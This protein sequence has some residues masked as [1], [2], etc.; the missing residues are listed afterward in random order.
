MVGDYDVS[1]PLNES[2]QLREV[3]YVARMSTLV[4]LG[5]L[6]EPVTLEGFVPATMSGQVQ[7]PKEGENLTF[8]GYSGELLP[9]GYPTERNATGWPGPVL[10]ATMWAVDNDVCALATGTDGSTLL[11]ALPL[12]D[13]DPAF[14]CAGT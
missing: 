5:L 8:V 7:A 10:E 13:S 9:L 2:T 3:E 12:D 1:A 6:K 14:P 11:C 4:G